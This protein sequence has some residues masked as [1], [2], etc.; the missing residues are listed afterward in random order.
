MTDKAVKT[1]GLLLV[2]AMA[3]SLI[4]ACYLIVMKLIF[5]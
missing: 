4:V 2:T 1:W 5:K 3:A